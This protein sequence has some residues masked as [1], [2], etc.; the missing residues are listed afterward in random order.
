[1]THAAS[2]GVTSNVGIKLDR[3]SICFNDENA[4]H[5]KKTVGL[6][7]DDHITKFTPSLKVTQNARYRASCRLALSSFDGQVCTATFEAGPRH[8][9]MSSYRLELN[10]AKMQGG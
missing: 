8:P 5:V 2:T 1:M 3:L 4:D 6:L 7:I 10:P 9:G